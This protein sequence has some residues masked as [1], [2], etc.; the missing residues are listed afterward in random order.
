MSAMTVFG[1]AAAARRSP[2]GNVGLRAGLAARAETM[3]A[4][5]I[6]ARCG[7]DHFT[8]RPVRRGS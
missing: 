2:S 1:G 8:Q 6:C 3:E 4:F 5:R 7:V